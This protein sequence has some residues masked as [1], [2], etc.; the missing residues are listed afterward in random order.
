MGFSRKRRFAQG[1]NLGVYPLIGLRL[2]QSMTGP[3][4][5]PSPVEAKDLNPG[6]ASHGVPV[7]FDA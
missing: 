6:G 7:P 3:C 5:R 4:R 1:V 2:L